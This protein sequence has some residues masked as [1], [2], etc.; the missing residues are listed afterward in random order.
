MVQVRDFLQQPDPSLPGGGR[1]L[2]R[3]K[4]L[5]RRAAMPKFLMHLTASRESGRRASWGAARE[6]VCYTSLWPP[7]MVVSSWMCARAANTWARIA[8]TSGIQRTAAG[9]PVGER[10]T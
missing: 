3:R 8:S 2:V 9:P 1:A 4:P 6:Y 7:S 5:G 10:R